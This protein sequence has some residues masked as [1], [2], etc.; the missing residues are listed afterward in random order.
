MIDT[1]GIGR[2]LSNKGCPY[3]NAVVE[4]LYNV[5]KTEFI[6]GKVFS[7]L[8]QLH[9]EL[10]DY[11]NWYNNHRLHGSLNYLTPIEYKREGNKVNR[12]VY[13]DVVNL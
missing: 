4:S 6:K 7:S 9:I 3:D 1:F 12:Y 10:A 11:V 13:Q 2:S 5:L 8:E